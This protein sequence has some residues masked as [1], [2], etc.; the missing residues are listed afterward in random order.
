MPAIGIARG[1]IDIMEDL[2]RTRRSVGGVA[3]G[4]LQSVHLRIAES[5]A[6]VDT[7][8]ALL[9]QDCAQATALVEA[10]KTMTLDHRIRWRRNDAFGAKVSVA[11]VERL[12]TL[13]GARGLGSDSDFM[14]EW[15]DVHAASTQLALAWD[16]NATNY[17]KV[18]FGLPFVDP[19]IWPIQEEEMVS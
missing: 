7:A 1:A 6:E 8:W 16:V 18:R 19:R 11:A 15:R 3:L 14:R 12:F 13:A 5:A 4:E 2:L 17:S 10:G 9:C